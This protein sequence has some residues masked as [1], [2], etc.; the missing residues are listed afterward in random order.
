MA[1]CCEH[2]DDCPER[3]ITRPLHF[4]SLL[5]EIL[6]F[7]SALSL[8][9]SLSLYRNFFYYSS[10]GAAGAAAGETS[11][12][13]Y[14]L[15][16][17]G[18]RDAKVQPCMVTM[19]LAQFHPLYVSSTAGAEHCAPNPTRHPFKFI[20]FQ[21]RVTSSH[22]RNSAFEFFRQM[23]VGAARHKSGSAREET[24]RHTHDAIFRTVL[25]SFFF[26]LLKDGDDAGRRL[27]HSG[28]MARD[29]DV[30]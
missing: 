28:M 21:P 7:S 16:V 20:C 15:S 13:I 9:L 5:Y 2:A 18:V 22:S 27:H 12:L 29:N 14:G 10:A 24:A 3:Y 11:H 4:F 19:P 25:F 8:S 17:A 30:K 26:L 23:T 1:P 6:I